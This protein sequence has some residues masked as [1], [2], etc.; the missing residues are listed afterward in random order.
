MV[1]LSTSRFAHVFRGVTGESPMQYVERLRL[2]QA[3]QL[4]LRTDLTIKEI[5]IRSGFVDAAY[6]STRF[7]RR[8]GRAPSVWRHR[9]TR[10]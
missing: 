9:P 7:R 4:L 6:F 3:E 10:A 2:E 1:H 8:Y 5:A